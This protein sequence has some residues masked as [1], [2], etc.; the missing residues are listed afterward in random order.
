LQNYGVVNFVPF[1]GPPCISMSVM[2]F[3]VI[4]AFSGYVDG[5]K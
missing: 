4:A 3:I 1:F 2:F 5:Q